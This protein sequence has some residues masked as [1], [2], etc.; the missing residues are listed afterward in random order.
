VTAAILVSAVF[1]NLSFPPYFAVFLTIYFAVIGVILWFSDIRPALVGPLLVALA[2]LMVVAGAVAGVAVSNNMDLLDRTA[3]G[4]E[5]GISS[6][7][8]LYIWR[9][10]IPMILDRP[11]LG[12]GPDNFA[13]PFEPYVSENLRAALTNP[14]GGVQAVDRAH[15]DVLQIAATMGLLGLAAYLWIFVSYF[16]SAYRSGGWPLLALSGG[17]L[18]YILQLQLSFPSAA[19]NVAFWGLLGSSVAIMRLQ[20]QGSDEPSRE[21]AAKAEGV[22]EATETPGARRYELLV[23][24][25][26]CIALISLSVPTFLDQRQEAAEKARDDLVL[27]VSQSVRVYEQARASGGTYPEAGVYTRQRPIKAGGGLKFRPSDNVEITTTT[28]G[29][30]FRVEGESTSL[31][32]TF[33]ASYDSATDK[34]TRPPS[35]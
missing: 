14:S 18:A 35:W 10:T 27:N 12:H 17:L 34:Y 4:R 15:N 11:L 32:G 21:D 1:G 20:G 7:V 31:S 30:R 22:G 3:V 16:L 6:Q 33:K 19:S 8:R 28:S 9:D 26:V 25:V 5:G 29:D 23:V 24:A 13:E 2:V